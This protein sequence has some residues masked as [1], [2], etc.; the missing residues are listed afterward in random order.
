MVLRAL[1][2]KFLWSKEEE[3]VTVETQEITTPFLPT[4]P[5]GH[6]GIFPRPIQLCCAVYTEALWHRGS[7]FS[8]FSQ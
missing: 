7:L 5:S 3:E 1:Q 8:L 4:K 6:D 2:E